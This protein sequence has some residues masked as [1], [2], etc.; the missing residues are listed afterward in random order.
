V[1][2]QHRKRKGET[3]LRRHDYQETRVRYWQDLLGKQVREE[4]LA[5]VLNDIAPLDVKKKKRA[6]NLAWR[7]M[8]VR[9]LNPN[10]RMIEL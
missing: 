8:I 7:M 6:A 5:M 10:A 9:G 2:K 4:L 3:G 1:W